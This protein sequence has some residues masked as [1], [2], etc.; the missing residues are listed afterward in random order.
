MKEIVQECYSKL[1]ISEILDNNTQNTFL[2]LICLRVSVEE[3]LVLEE[4]Y[5]ADKIADVIRDIRD[6]TCLDTDS[7]SIKLYKNFIK[8]LSKILCHT[9][10]FLVSLISILVDF[11]KRII[12]SIFK[13][14]KA[15][16]LKNY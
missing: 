2:D 16:K 14:C 12:I 8:E 10:R 5:T 15:T 4:E 7:F 6:S 13:K 1:F 9:F 11:T 3:S